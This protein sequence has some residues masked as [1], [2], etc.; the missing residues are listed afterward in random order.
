LLSP[1]SPPD[2]ADVARHY[3]ELGF[4]YRHLW[5]DHLHHGVWSNSTN[6]S[7]AEEATARLLELAVAPLDIH[8]G[9][10]L[11]DIGCGYG[12]DARWI[13][14]TTGA[15]VTGLTL[16]AHQVEIA[17]RAP[18]PG[19][20]HLVIHHG[21]WLANEYP[22]H[23]F[24]AAIAIE[25]LAHMPDQPAFFR[26][27]GRTLAPAGRAAIACW[28]AAPNLSF[29]EAAL[30]RGI[31]RVGR[32]PSLGTLDEFRALAV[33]AG[34]RVTARRDLTAQVAPT[35]Q[36][37]SRR[38]LASLFTN[39]RFLLASIRCTLRR[40]AYALILPAMILA[41]NT[42]ALRYALLWLERPAA[43]VAPN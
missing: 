43:Q 27:L 2:Q 25:S 33:S 23:A 19:R 39:P 15:Q 28:N 20:G 16:S 21:D 34:M 17:R 4:F 10:R 6:D 40:P 18:A 35:W 8:S 9:Q 38:A 22:D 29:L 3:D 12:T 26:Q 36:L 24:D 30:L 7:S 37:I 41:C 5:G 1:R 13:A 32:L 31:C 42:G 14:E 11:V